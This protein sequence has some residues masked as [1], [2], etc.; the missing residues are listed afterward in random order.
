MSGTKRKI[1]NL[2]RAPFVPLSESFLPQGFITTQ[3]PTF[4]A[5]LICSYPPFLGFKQITQAQKK[6]QRLPF[7]SQQGTLYNVPI[8][9]QMASHELLLM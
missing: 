8:K 4:S 9:C 1:I 5:K 3:G 2:L 6:A 7:G